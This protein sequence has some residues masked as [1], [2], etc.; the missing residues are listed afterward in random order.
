[1]VD[2]ALDIV[3]IEGWPVAKRGKKSGAKR[4]LR[5]RQCGSDMVIPR[6]QKNPGKKCPECGGSMEDLF[7][8]A[9]KEGKSKYEFPEA[10]QL[11]SRVMR[12]YRY[13]TL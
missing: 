2:F 6:G 5:C 4:V 10:E 8:E 12:Q 13:L 3:E 7:M 9:V 11:R 1:M